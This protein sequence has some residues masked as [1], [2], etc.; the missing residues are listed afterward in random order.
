MWQLVWCCSCANGCIPQE[1]SVGFEKT[2]KR[3]RQQRMAVASWQTLWKGCA[4]GAGRWWDR[5]VKQSWSNQAQLHGERMTT[6]LGAIVLP[7]VISTA[8]RYWN[9]PH[10]SPVCPWLYIFCRNARGQMQI[11]IFECNFSLLG[12]DLMSEVVNLF[13]ANILV[14]IYICNAQ[15]CMLDESCVISSVWLN[16]CIWVIFHE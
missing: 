12:T 2:V 6:G 1:V 8:S 4:V 15:S 16:H 9:W 10:L 11:T 3:A 7:G 5:V 14:W 13:V